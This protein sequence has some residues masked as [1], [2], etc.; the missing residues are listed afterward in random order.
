MRL[1]GSIALA[2]VAIACG[3]FGEAPEAN[4]PA[5]PPPSDAGAGADADVADSTPP[6]KDDASAQPCAIG[7]L[8]CEHFENGLG[9]WSFVTAAFKTEPVAGQGNVLTVKLP[10]GGNPDFGALIE[11]PIPGNAT[12]VAMKFRFRATDPG[13]TNEP[14]NSNYAIAGIRATSGT[15][16]Y[17]A[18]Y[19]ARGND[20][21]VAT[22]QVTGSSPQ[23]TFKPTAPTQL[24]Y[25]AWHTVEIQ[26]ALGT[27]AA[28]Q[29]FV[30]GQ[31]TGGTTLTSNKVPLSVVLGARRPN[32]ATPPISVELDDVVVVGN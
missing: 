14:S 7:E 17:A 4:G 21:G 18:L 12:S 13:Y 26:L 29:W 15:G 11:R 2:F 3:S 16:A 24:A 28:L 22:A 10:A 30:E 5:P 27:N 32:S 25:G 9:A 20:P 6:P 8:I 19:L 31:L 23:E 1:R